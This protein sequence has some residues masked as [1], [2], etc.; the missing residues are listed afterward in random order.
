MVLD[1]LVT[2]LTSH[3]PV[4]ETIGPERPVSVSV[5]WCVC[6]VPVDEDILNPETKCSSVPSSL[7]C[8]ALHLQ[9][10][11]L[12]GPRLGEAVHF[13]WTSSYHV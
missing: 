6:V 13:N 2:S 5:H 4:V 7:R 11:A 3:I 1:F 9:L 10:L 12:Q 8:H